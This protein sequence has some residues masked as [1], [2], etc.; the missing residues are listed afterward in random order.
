MLRY[1]EAST[2]WHFFKY[3]CFFFWFFLKNIG[4]Q[5]MTPH[6][7]IISTR[8]TKSVIKSCAAMS[9]VEAQAR[10][11]DRCLLFQLLTLNMLSITPI[12]LQLKHCHK[13]GS[14]S[15]DFQPFG[16][17]PNCRPAELKLVSKGLLLYWLISYCN[18]CS[19]SIAIYHWNVFLL[20]LCFEC[21]HRLWGIGV[22]KEGL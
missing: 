20:L 3:W 4:L 15:L 2:P 6:A 14:F 19:L 1:C 12:V 7:D 9:Y 13:L 16:R 17:S 10:M 8:Y 22:V 18:W 5:E 11:D 21:S